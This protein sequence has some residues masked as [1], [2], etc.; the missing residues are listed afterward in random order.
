MLLKMKYLLP[1]LLFLLLTGCKKEQTPPPQSGTDE[2]VEFKMN[3]TLNRL[4]GSQEQVVS[5]VVFH[6]SPN[7]LYQLVIS[8]N[9]T[10][11]V[12]SFTLQV[13][14]GQTL[15]AKNYVRSMTNPGVEI[16]QVVFVTPQLNTYAPAINTPGNIQ[17]TRLERQPGGYIE[18]TFAFANMDYRDKNVNMLSSNHALTEGKFRVKV[19]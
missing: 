15:E 4:G 14:S 5:A 9:A 16:R 7:F 13:G 10:P 12:R 8:V 3:N 19:K 11:N 6:D 1:G 17:L 18:G 2:Y